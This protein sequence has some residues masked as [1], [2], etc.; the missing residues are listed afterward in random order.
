MSCL[1]RLNIYPLLRAARAGFDRLQLI[2]V[3][4]LETLTSDLG[5]HSKAY[6][7]GLST[8]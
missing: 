3:K 7:R 6:S 8:S 1:V 4:E 2:A 5:T